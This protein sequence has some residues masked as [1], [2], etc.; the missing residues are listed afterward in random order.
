MMIIQPIRMTTKA[1]INFKNKTITILKMHSSV[2][3]STGP[4]HVHN[5]TFTLLNLILMLYLI[6]GHSVLYSKMAVEELGGR[7][8]KE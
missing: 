2:L 8:G 5:R 3:S 1:M 7:E 6:S 4:V